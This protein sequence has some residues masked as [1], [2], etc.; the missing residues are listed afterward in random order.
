MRVGH[1]T[2]IQIRVTKKA[3]W[4]MRGPQVGHGKLR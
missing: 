4:A 2:D 3:L 1:E